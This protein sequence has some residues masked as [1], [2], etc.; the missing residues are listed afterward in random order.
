MA[1]QAMRTPHINTFKEV[2]PV[3]YCYT[4]PGVP[5]HNGWCKIGETEQSPEARVAQQA[6][7]INVETKL[8]WTKNAIFDDGKGTPFHDR[9]FHAYLTRNGIERMK[10]K[11]GDKKAPEWFRITPKTAKQMLNDFRDNK[12]L[13]PSE[14]TVI[15]YVLRAEQQ[16]AVVKAKDYFAT[17]EGGQFL[18]NCKP[19]F[20]KTLTVYDL[21]KQMNL[22]KVLIVTNR[23]AIANSWYEDY[24]K[25]LGEESGYYFVSEASGVKGNPLV[26]S[27]SGFLNKMIEQKK[28]LKCIEF[29]SLQDL[30]GSKYFGG[31]FDKLKEVADMNW[32]ILVV[33]E[34]HEGVDTYKTDV[35]F[36]RIHRKYTL[37]LSGTP[38]K[39]IAKQTFSEDAMYSWTYADEQKAK[40][41]WHSDD[42]SPN[43]YADLPQLNMYTYQMSDIVKD[44]LEQGIEINGETEEY[45]FDLNEFFATDN[46]GY[47]VHNDAV[48]K[49]LDTLIT[50]KKYPFST[51]ELRN[52]LKHTLWFLDRVDSA[53]ALERKLKKHPVFGKYEIVL[54]AGDG[55]SEEEDERVKDSAFKRVKEAIKNHDKTITLTVGQLTTGVTIPEW[56]AVLMLSNVRSP[57][58]Y[59]QAAFRAQNPCRFHSGLKFYRKKNAYVFDFDPA[60]TLIT[61][62]QFANDLSTDTAAGHGNTKTREQHIKELLNFF[63]V[64]GED[65]QGEMVALDA[66]KVL[67]IPR[68]IKSTEVVNRGFMSNYLFQNISNVFGAPQEVVDI[69]SQMTPVKEDEALNQLTEDTKEQLDINDHGEV[70]IPEDTIHN[71]AEDLFGKKIYKDTGETLQQEASKIADVFEPSSSTDTTDEDTAKAQEEVKKKVEDLKAKFAEQATKQ[72]LDQAQDAYQGDLSKQT[73]N[74]LE[75]HINDRIGEQL[76]KAVDNHRID[77]SRAQSERDEKLKEMETPEEEKKVRDDYQEKIKQA[78]QNLQKTVTKEIQ[79]GLTEAGQ[80]VVERV[81]T[82]KKNKQKQTIE[83]GVRDHLRGFSRTIPSFLMAYG[84]DNTITLANFDKIVPEGVFKDVTSI[85]LKQFRF[86]RDGGDYYQKDDKGHEI[87]DEAHKKHY[88]GH[89]FDEVVF[90]D[91]VKEFMN[92]KKQLANYFDEKN[93]EDIFN[94]IPPQQTN[95]I[96]TPKKVVKHMV[97]L[98]EKENPGCF[99]DDAKTFADLYMKSGM[100]ITEIVKRL[101]NSPRMKQLYPDKEKRL[102]HI[103]AKQVYGLAPT[104]IIYR[105]CKN[106]ILGFSDTISIKEHHIRLCDSLVYAQKGTLD[107]KLEEMFPKLKGE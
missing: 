38:F 42:G 19:R 82:D 90:N 68:K 11:K 14:T 23:P 55:R 25:F 75:K 62:E 13:L 39:S 94:Y 58:L 37:H 34:A 53:R 41:E 27:R 87:R 61:Y 67:S 107:M 45:A 85:T 6:Q 15:P 40:A 106:Y 73:R 63:P 105:I 30:K 98:L 5:A 49:F 10:P 26:L 70:D 99:D 77:V 29:V 12:G 89:L 74:S 59:M 78:N 64:I 43:P 21:C 100:F 71:E 8:E 65:D 35:A 80:T 36:D 91:S 88:E 48:N 50:G 24:C 17:H 66:T 20:G 76:D 102:N 44:Q 79:N 9:D 47:F 46:R 31:G 86:L 3:I 4:T 69:I 96:F 83:G 32:D 52:E 60:R 33:D 1:A 22:V 81:E 97:D 51:P 92:K 7:T 103:F 16:A 93:T 56:T 54:A 72:I 57:A 84:T 104:E 18:F 95:Q 28:E 2:I 101:Y